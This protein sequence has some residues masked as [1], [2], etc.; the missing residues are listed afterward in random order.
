MK[1]LMLIMTLVLFS[2]AAWSLDEGLARSYSQYFQPFDGKA[3]SK[4]L[5]FVKVPDFVNA[6]KSGEKLFIRNR[7]DPLSFAGGLDK[8]P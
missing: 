4:A 2:S 1:K 8:I 5:H 3:T 6:I 7:S